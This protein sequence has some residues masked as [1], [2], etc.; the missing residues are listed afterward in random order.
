MLEVFRTEI[1]ITHIE[2]DVVKKLECRNTTRIR[3]TKVCNDFDH[4]IV[5]RRHPEDLHAFLLVVCP[6]DTQY[7]DPNKMRP[8]FQPEVDECVVRVV[9]TDMADAFMSST[10]SRSMRGPHVM[11]SPVSS[12]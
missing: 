3:F 1:G 2:V 7:V 8:F 11:D 12:S 5:D 4:L 10:S 9:S 6:V